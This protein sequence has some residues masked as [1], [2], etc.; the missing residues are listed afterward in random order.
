ME[1]LVEYADQILL[2]VAILAVLAFVAGYAGY[3][4]WRRYNNDDQGPNM[5]AGFSL[6]E[7]RVM[8]RQGNLTDE[9][10]EQAKALIIGRTKTKPDVEMADSPGRESSQGNID[11]DITFFDDDDEDVETEDEENPP[12]SPGK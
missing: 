6:H 8:H 4:L 10:F 3:R 12:D 5:S 2:Y 1:A 7:L 9:E 11:S